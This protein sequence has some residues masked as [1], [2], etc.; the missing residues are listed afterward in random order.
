MNIKL[1]LAIVSPLLPAIFV[2]QRSQTLCS[3][4]FRELYR[5]RIVE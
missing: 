3:K 4:E 1:A 5:W 2:L